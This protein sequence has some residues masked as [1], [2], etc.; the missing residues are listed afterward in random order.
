[1]VVLLHCVGNNNKE[2]SLLAYGSNRI[3]F[4]IFIAQLVETTDVEPMDIESRLY[5][6]S[7]VITALAGN[8][9]FVIAEKNEWS[10]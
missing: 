6:I 8:S 1:M 4:N 2:K 7:I 10:S 5:M 9:S 3:V